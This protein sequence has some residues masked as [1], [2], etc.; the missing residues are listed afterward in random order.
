MAENS[1]ATIGDVARQVGVSVVAVSR[2]LSST[3]PVIDET[4][5]MCTPIEEV[6]RAAMRQLI[7]VDYKTWKRTLKDSGEWYSRVIATNSVE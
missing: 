2:V 7:R 6:G 1:S 3:A 5:E 4:V